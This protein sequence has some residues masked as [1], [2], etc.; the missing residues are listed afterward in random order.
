MSKASYTPQEL[1]DKIKVLKSQ[2]L[3]YDFLTATVINRLIQL[4][5]NS[6]NANNIITILEDER[7]K[8][9][10]NSVNTSF[11]TEVYGTTKQESAFYLSIKKNNKNFIHLT[12]VM[13]QQELKKM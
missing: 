4:F 2:T 5:D 7:K 1:S 8:L 6:N 9:G 11:K 12:M 3:I 10:L 13:L